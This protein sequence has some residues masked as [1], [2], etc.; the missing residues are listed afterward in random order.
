M[1]TDPPGP[2]PDTFDIRCADAVELVTEY[3]DGAL[4][5]CDLA[6]FEAHLAHCEGCT[7]FVDQ[8][9]MTIHLT[10]AT[11]GTGPEIMPPDLDELLARLRER[12]T[13]TGPTG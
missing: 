3:L 13:G 1:T 9:R 10:C 8:I 6:A 12:A 7:V 2:G 11:S 5:A 4:G